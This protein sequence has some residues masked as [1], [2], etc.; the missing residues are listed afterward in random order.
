MNAIIRLS[1]AFLALLT[2]SAL[3]AKDYIRYV[4]PFVGTD[5]HGHTFPA[6][7][8]PFGMVQA[9]PDTRINGW[10]GCSGY[11][12]SD[13]II[14]GFTHTHLSG[15]GCSDYGDVLFMP[16]SGKKI[17]SRFSHEREK[18]SPGCYEVWLDD[19]GVEVRIASG[20][21]MAMHSYTYGKGAE[22]A[23]Y[24]DLHYRDRLLGSFLEMDGNAAIKG[25]RQSRSWAREQDVY[26]YAQFSEPVEKAELIDSASARLSFAPGEKPLKVKI[27]LSSVSCGNA[28]ENLLAEK[29]SGDWDFEGLA[30]STANAWNDWLSRIDVKCGER[31]KNTFYT[32]MYHCAVHPSLYSDVNGEYRG[33]DRKVHKAVGYDRY[34]LFSIWDA[35]RSAFPLYNMI[36]RDIMPD[37]LESMLSIYKEGGRL[38]RW[39]LA[40]NETDCMIGYNAVSIIAD[41]Y[42]KGTLPRFRLREYYDAMKGTSLAERSGYELFCR[43]GYDPAGEDDQSVSKTLEYAYD[44][45]CIASIAKVLGE[46]DDYEEYIKRAQYWKNVYDPDS[47]FMRPRETGRWAA[48]FDPAKATSHFTEANSWQYSFFVPQDIQGHIDIMGGREAFTAKL[49]ALFAA[50]NE[51]LS[52]Q[53]V[54]LEGFVGQYA[55]GNEPSHHIAYLYDFAGQPWKTQELTRRICGKFYDDTPGGLS[56]NEDCGQ[57]SAWYV[58]SSLGMYSVTPGTSIMALTA[59]LVE[60]A[61]V[62]LGGKFFKVVSSDSG[63]RYIQSV[64]LNGKAYDG[65]AVDFSD[66]IGGGSIEFTMGNAPSSF[67]KEPVMVTSIDAPYRR[68]AYFEEDFGKAREDVFVSG[69]KATPLVPYYSGYTAGGDDGVVDGR[70]GKLNWRAGYWQGY[71]GTDV[72][73]L[74]E[75]LSPAEIKSVSVGFLQD[76]GNYI[77]MPGEMEVYLSPDG[78]NFTPA[79]IRRS[80]VA[81]DEEQIIIQDWKV[82]F[83]PVWTKYVRI[84]AHPFG[85]IPSW[86]RGYGD[87]SFIFVDEISVEN[88]D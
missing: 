29:D 18:A 39:E 77:W 24:V 52:E 34:T 76:M 25:W 36:A 69:L 48:D 87:K 41:S 70:R 43:Y 28:R 71:R 32:A 35:F 22:R 8:Y 3:D 75:L 86:H 9:G 23:V 37:F 66:I 57:M 13:S 84:V 60:K 30:K 67:G 49:D 83:P 63:C 27:A 31:Q 1:V 47:G 65:A 68:D 64:R 82:E 79:G 12:Y 85:E 26:F 72:D 55:H 46:K 59:P 19:P 44:D 21:R 42:V 2:A 62:N 38:P 78:Q 53:L 15:T 61:T 14:L 7:T 73:I 74:V 80:D 16:V 5:G 50:D 58:L 88:N 81:I 11:H 51:G 6:A 54:D 10:D 33:M 45:W 40:G 17:Q 4:N 20:R 56:G